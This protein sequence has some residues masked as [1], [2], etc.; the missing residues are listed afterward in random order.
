MKRILSFMLALMM[1]LGCSLMAFAAVNAEMCEFCDDGTVRQD[2]WEYVCD[3][4]PDLDCGE[5]DKCGADSYKEANYYVCDSCGEIAYWYTRITTK[6]GISNN[7]YHSN[8][9]LYLP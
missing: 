7:E 6:C 9:T 2:G 3:I 5:H 4:S 8:V 1:L